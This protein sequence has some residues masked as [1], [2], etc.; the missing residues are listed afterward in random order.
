MKPFTGKKK[1]KFFLKED[2]KESN[3]WPIV[4][5]SG[6]SKTCR[7]SLHTSPQG[8][9]VISNLGHFTLESD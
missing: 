3:Y 8:V 1:L 5:G 4:S 9:S 6:I 2:M 7:M